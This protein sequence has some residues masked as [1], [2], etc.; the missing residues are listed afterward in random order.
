VP[1][2][3]RR[4]PGRSRVRAASYMFTGVYWPLIGGFIAFIL[5]AVFLGWVIDSRGGGTERDHH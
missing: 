1:S 3:G 5:L 2:T 4:A